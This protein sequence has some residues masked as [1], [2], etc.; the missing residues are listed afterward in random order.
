MTRQV[1]VPDDQSTYLLAGSVRKALPHGTALAI[2]GQAVYVLVRPAWRHG[3][4]CN[5]R[6]A[7]V[8]LELPSRD[9]I[10]ASMVTYDVTPYDASLV[11][12]PTRVTV[13]PSGAGDLTLAYAL[14]DVLGMHDWVVA[15]RRELEDAVALANELARQR[16]MHSVASLI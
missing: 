9:I 2:D 15:T 11:K 5:I 1:I 7:Q 3:V 14:R 4:P 13:A 12:Q 6:D 8:R 16:R 10:P